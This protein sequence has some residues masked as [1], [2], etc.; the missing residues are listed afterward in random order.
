MGFQYTG[1][2]QLTEEAKKRIEESKGVL[3]LYEDDIL[4]GWNLE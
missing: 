1:T 4:V 2:I 3:P